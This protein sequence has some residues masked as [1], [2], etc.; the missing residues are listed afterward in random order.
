APAGQ[1]HRQELRGRPP[2]APHYRG[3]RGMPAAVMYKG[4]AERP[5][6]TGTAW[7]A[8]PT[9]QSVGIGATSMD[10]TTLSDGAGQGERARDPPIWSTIQPPAWSSGSRPNGTICAP[11]A[12]A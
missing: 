1:H 11:A 4:R 8:V 10:G 12:Q 7:V 9:R 2:E 5:R 3:K 6:R